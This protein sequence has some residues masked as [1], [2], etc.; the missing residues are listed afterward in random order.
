MIACFVT[1]KSDVG[2]MICQ[3]TGGRFCHV[4][5]ILDDGRAVTA[6]M[7]R[8][9]VVILDKADPEHPD[10]NPTD[11]VRVNLPARWTQT[12]DLTRYCEAI[13]K[14]KYS[15]VNA[16]DA[17]YGFPP[18]DPGGMCCSQVAANVMARAGAPLMNL[19]IPPSGTNHVQ[20]LYEWIQAEVATTPIMQPQTQL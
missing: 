17:G 2:A 9:A 3:I 20:G 18:S 19:D 10:A 14:L 8:N 13:A 5:L 7:E 15:P 11:W 1:P 16:V 4:A 6:L 12:P